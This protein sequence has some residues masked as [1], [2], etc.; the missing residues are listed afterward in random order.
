MPEWV[1]EAQPDASKF[2]EWFRQTTSSTTK[3]A[4]LMAGVLLIAEITGI[5]PAFQHMER[6]RRALRDNNREEQRL[7]RRVVVDARFIEDVKRREVAHAPTQVEQEA[8]SKFDALKDKRQASF[9]DRSKPRLTLDEFKQLGI[10]TSILRE[11]ERLPHD[12]LIADKMEADAAVTAASI[13]EKRK[14]LAGQLAALKEKSDVPFEI[15]GQK[16]ALPPLAACILWSVLAIAL[17]RY[18]A[19]Q[20]R[21]VLRATREELTRSTPEELHAA[22]RR[23]VDWWL[24]PVPKTLAPPEGPGA[25]LEAFDWTKSYLHL[26]SGVLVAIILIIAANGFVLWR[27][28]DLTQ[29]FSGTIVHAVMLPA[30]VVLFLLVVS[31]AVTF[32]TADGAHE[33]HVLSAFV[34]YGI[35]IA[36]SVLLF[37]ARP[38]IGSLV[39]ARLS[40]WMPFIII[41]AAT[42]VIVIGIETMIASSP[43]PVARRRAVRSVLVAVAGVAMLSMSWPLKRVPKRKRARKTRR[44]RRSTGERMLVPNA[45]RDAFYANRHSEV[46][47]Y[48]SK[49]KTYGKALPRNLIYAGVGI[50]EWKGDISALGS[51]VHLGRASVMVEEAALRLFSSGRASDV[52]AGCRLLLRGIQHDLYYKNGR[53]GRISSRLWDLLAGMAVRHRLLDYTLEIEKLIVANQLEPYLK[54]RMRRWTNPSSTWYVRWSRRESKMRWNGVMLS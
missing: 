10:A 48:V 7:E 13:A 20:R 30:V 9:R 2:A 43:I 1:S 15:L 46:L 37:L 16:L 24:A 31:S 11:R 34:V 19:A 33:R 25:M 36:G 41:A 27:A 42:F 17:L 39:I 18:L 44:R 50:P 4:V 21:V 52:D 54:D 6:S 32:L 26:A 12:K 5:E 14:A 38:H 40:A 51:H 45:K 29:S 28:L 35:V 47:Y 8:L 53:S 22:I 23:D 3:T 49:G